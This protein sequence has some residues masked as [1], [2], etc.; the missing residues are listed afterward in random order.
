MQN[1]S[2]TSKQLDNWMIAVHRS[3]LPG[4]YMY[5]AWIYEHGVLLLVLWPLL[6][7]N[8]P[9]TTVEATCKWLPLEMVAG[10]RNVGL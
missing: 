10:P 9:L 5:K 4:K 6:V 8:V 1:V 3:S 2:D 7:Y